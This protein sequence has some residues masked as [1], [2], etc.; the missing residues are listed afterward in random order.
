LTNE[1]VFLLVNPKF[2]FVEPADWYLRVGFMMDGWRFVFIWR[3]LC[4]G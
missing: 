1:K 4:P 2:H 3:P